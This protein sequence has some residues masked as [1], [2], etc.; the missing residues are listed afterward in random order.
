[1][2]EA[3]MRVAPAPRAWLAAPTRVGSVGIP[4]A[5]FLDPI[6]FMKV[7][8]CVTVSDIFENFSLSD[9]LKYKYSRKQQLAFGTGLIG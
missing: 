9:F 2:L 4:R 3:A 5:H 7:T 1:M 6:V 8:V